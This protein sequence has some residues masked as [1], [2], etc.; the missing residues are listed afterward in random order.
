MT[1]KRK[2]VKTFPWQKFINN[3]ACARVVHATLSGKP[4][5]YVRVSRLDIDCSSDR[6][7]IRIDKS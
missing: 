3:S 5:F 1:R 4:M 2:N 7:V 6:G